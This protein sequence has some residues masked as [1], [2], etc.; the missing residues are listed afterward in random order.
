M[1]HYQVLDNYLFL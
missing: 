1:D